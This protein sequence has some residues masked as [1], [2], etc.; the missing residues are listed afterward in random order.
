MY[1]RCCKDALLYYLSNLSISDSTHVGEELPSARGR[2]ARDWRGSAG[3]GRDGGGGRG[4]S[5]GRGRRPLC[6]WR[7]GGF[8]GTARDKINKA[9]AIASLTRWSCDYIEARRP[10]RVRITEPYLILSDI[11]TTIFLITLYLSH[12]RFTRLNVTTN[13]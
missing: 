2:P 5:G 12:R 6:C 9:I 13:G 3:S 10:G 4:L 11:T 7:C 8:G 1:K